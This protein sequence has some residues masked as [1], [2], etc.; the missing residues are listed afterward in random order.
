MKA[1]NQILEEK[2]KSLT[3]GLQVLKELFLAHTSRTQN[4]NSEGF[5]D[6]EKILEDIPDEK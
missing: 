3:K 2:V 5:I 4:T 6:F 1:E